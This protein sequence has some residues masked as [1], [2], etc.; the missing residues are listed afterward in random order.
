MT[1]PDGNETTGTITIDVTPDTGDNVDPTANNDA[2]DAM[3]GGTTVFAPLANDSDPEG[4][5]LTITNVTV[6]AGKGSATINADGT[7]SYTAPAG[8]DED[9]VLTYTISDGNGGTDTGAIT[10]SV[11][12]DAGD[13]T[14]V[15]DRIPVET[16]EASILDVL[17]N[18]TLPEGS[19][20]TSISTPLNGT[21]TLTP[22]GAI[23]YTSTDGFEGNDTL[24]Y[25]VTTPDG[26]V[27]TGTVSLSV[28]DTNTAPVA[29][30]DT[31]SGQS[32]E[33]IV[34]DVLDNDSDA[35]NDTLTITGV[36]VPEGKGSASINADGT[37]TYTAPAGLDEDVVLSYTISDGNGGTDTGA[38]TVSVT[39]GTPDG[40]VSGTN[41]GDLI[42]PE[43]TGDPQGEKVDN[44]D[45]IDPTKAPN[46]DVI[47]AGSGD[48]TVTAGLGD[49]VV[50]GGD[51]DDNIDGEGGDD[52]LI[53]GLGNDTIKGGDGRDTAQG[54]DGN[55]VID[56][57]AAAEIIDA[58]TLPTDAVDAAPNDDRDSVDGG[59]GDDSIRTGD[60]NDTIVGGSGNDTIDSGLDDD[61]VLGGDGAD[62]ITTSHGSD[63]VFGG[64]GDDIINAEIA[65]P[66]GDLF[67]SD[68]NPV[69]AAASV[70]R[71]PN[72]NDDRDFIDA[73]EGNDYVT[74]GDDSDTI[75]GGTG[76]D[77]ISAG[78]DDDLIRGGQGDDALTG[79]DG[80]D[81]IYGDAGNDLI[82]GDVS[83]N[84]PGAVG[85]M[86]WND[87]ADRDAAGNKL[88]QLPN[89]NQDTLY[90][91]DGN[92]TILGQDDRDLLFG[93]GG[94]VL[95]EGGLDQDTI[96]GGE[97]SDTLRGDAG[98]DRIYGG[99]GDVVDGGEELD[100]N[101][102]ATT[103]D[104]LDLRNQLAALPEGTTVSITYDDNPENGTA[105]FLDANGVEL[106][107]MSFQNIERVVP[108]FTPGTQITTAEGL[109]SVE[110][111]QAGDLV[112]TR[113]RGFQAIE[114][115]GQKHI[116]ARELQ[117][118]D[119]LR[120]IK[121]S[122]GALGS[123]M[124]ER[125]LI[126]SPNHRVLIQSDVAA[127]MFGQ[128]EV[129]VAAKHLV[130]LD[131]VRV[132][133]AQADVTYVHFMCAQ[134][135]V[136]LSD[137][138]WTESFQPGDHSLAGLDAP[139]RS[140]VLELFPQLATFAGRNTYKAARMA[141]TKEEASLI[142]R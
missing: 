139:Q 8:L 112:L 39:T 123:S 116:A 38:I 134:H 101:A 20:I 7:I 56:L 41:A 83:P 3:A 70:A 77:T 27:L 59:A 99:I 135:E 50:D 17:A 87:H 45:Q 62:I 76:A 131:G 95:I 111:L 104:V 128:D 6:P 29:V 43:Y 49:D 31:A 79:D 67:V 54:G 89:N 25:T 53:G 132:L 94:D 37:I 142:A 65:N 58:Q 91:G 14:V 69:L 107:Q 73:G 9:V 84:S 105:V 64:D 68:A 133:G 127:Q 130:H 125:D 13:A 15:D 21:A 100:A 34:I 115:I 1:D 33:A 88:D 81:Q 46:D 136:V 66:Y 47:Q 122:A 44:L 78:I 109:K 103:F 52:S 10:V 140:E 124:P 119:N 72:A 96:Y 40:I 12:P 121:I 28:S 85:T 26:E 4:D 126:V 93:D 120:P 60:D 18:D 97:G 48:D 110:T 92:D 42:D 61:L 23:E 32:L 80:R 108:C 22:E 106:G 71:D 102:D 113:D 11:G 55:D 36:T 24:T 118:M 114:W 117:Q 137:G 75:L 2:F 98:E 74:S 5:T 35:D 141:I 30:D 129:L 63:S 138:A 19:K 57:A 90:G 51:G 86:Q 16:G 82:Y